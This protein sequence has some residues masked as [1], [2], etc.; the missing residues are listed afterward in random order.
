MILR[1]RSWGI[2]RLKTRRVSGRLGW[3]RD[4]ETAIREWLSKLPS[5]SRASYLKLWTDLKEKRSKQ[6][7]LVHQ[8][9]KVDMA[10]QAHKYGK[11]TGQRKM[12]DFYESATRSEERRVGKECR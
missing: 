3:R 9:D 11:R 5:K 7:R 10:F 1:R 2:S 6:A 8:L 12:L 4:R